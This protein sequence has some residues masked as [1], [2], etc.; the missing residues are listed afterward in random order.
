ME[1]VKDREARERALAVR[2]NFF[3]HFHPVKVRKGALGL[4][5]TFGLG[6]L[7]SLLFVLIVLSGAFLMVYYVPSEREAYGTTKD[8]QTAI[9]F[10]ALFRNMHRWAA[11]AMIITVFLHMCRVF[12]TGAYKEPRQYNWV[13][14]V[15]LLLLTLGLS[16][17]ASVTRISRSAVLDVLG[18]DYVRTARSK[19]APK[20]RVI[21]RHALPNALIPVVTLSGVEFGYLLGGAVL[22]RP[23][24]PLA[25]SLCR[26][27]G[28][29][30]RQVRRGEPAAGYYAH[31]ATEL[32]RPTHGGRDI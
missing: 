19:G 28:L 14:G 21:W 27:D 1:I 18:D 3:L 7:S 11:H 23:P 2:R 9:P 26:P 30:A 31:D 4:G 24:R 32:H 22:L 5:Y 8:I 16:F 25:R 17:T 20:A 15:G 13:M 29:S 10:G 12:F 6:G